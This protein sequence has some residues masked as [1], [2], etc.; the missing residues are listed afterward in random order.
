MSTITTNIESIISTNNIQLSIFSR[1]DDE[2]I[3][4][5]YLSVLPKQQEHH[6]GCTVGAN[7]MVNWKKHISE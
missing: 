7:N 1:L 3:Y 2:I 6:L 4:L 5:I